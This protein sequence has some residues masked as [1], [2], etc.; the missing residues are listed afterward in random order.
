MAYG[1]GWNVLAFG[2]WW[3]SNKERIMSVARQQ[4]FMVHFNAYDFKRYV[5]QKYI[6]PFIDEAQ[7]AA[8]LK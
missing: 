5:H 6:E 8:I 2:E 7:K 1:P 4:A 3:E